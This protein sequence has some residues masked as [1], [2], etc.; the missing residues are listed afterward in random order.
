MGQYKKAQVA[1]LARERYEHAFSVSI[2]E[3]IS[4]TFT[5]WNK[6]WLSEEVDFFHRDLLYER[7][8]RY[9]GTTWNAKTLQFG[10]FRAT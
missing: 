2:P 10:L 7:L 8:I 1:F 3:A 5:A 6:F 9:V 4:T